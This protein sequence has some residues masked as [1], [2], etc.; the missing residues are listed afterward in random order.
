[1]N[2]SPRAALTSLVNAGRLFLNRV[3]Q[4][5]TVPFRLLPRENSFYF[6][7]LWDENTEMK[8]RIIYEN[9]AILFYRSKTRSARFR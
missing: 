6:F 8:T 1:M 9:C 5:R 3:G 7:L 4:P 2:G